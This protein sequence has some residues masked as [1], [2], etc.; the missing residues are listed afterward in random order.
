MLAK[1]DARQAL[2]VHFSANALMRKGVD[3]PSDL[4]Q[5]LAGKEPWPLSC[6]VLTHG[7]HMNV[8]RSVGVILEPRAAEDVLRVHHGD[9][10]AYDDAGVNQSLGAV[11]SDATFDARSTI[12]SRVPTMSGA[13]VAPGRSA[14]S[15]STRRIS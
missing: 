7:H 9:A 2:I 4:K 12:P 8:T 10:G 6:S 11:L 5:V 15:C 14:S 3:F 1:L 13:C